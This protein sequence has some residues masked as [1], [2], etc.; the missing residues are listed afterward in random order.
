MRGW[1]LLI[2]SLLC[3]LT[4]RGQVFPD[5]V[6][7]QFY[8]NLGEERPTCI[9]RDR[10]GF[11]YLGGNSVIPDEME[12]DCANI[13]LVKVDA[14]GEIYWEQEVRLGGCEELRDMV[15]SQDGGVVFV[16]VTGSIV[17]GEEQGSEE[18]GGNY[19]AG[20]ID[21]VGQLEWIQS[22]GG[23]QLDQA[24]ALA[25]G[26]YR[27]FMLVGS[28]HSN[29]GQVDD[30]IGMS[31]LWTLKVDT[32]GQPRFSQ[33]LGSAGNDWGTS[34]ALT[35]EGDYLIAGYTQ[36]KVKSK[37][38]GQGW[39][40]RM[41]P[42][43]EILWDTVLYQPYGGYI[44]EIKETPR[45]N[46]AAVGYR[47]NEKGD[48]DFWW[49]LLDDQGKMLWQHSMD[50]PNQERLTSLDLTADGGLI[51]G[52]YAE[53]LL[54]GEG[55]YVK[56]G[57]DFWLL[58]TDSLGRLMW[59]KTYGGREDERCTGVVAYAPGVYYAIGEKVNR[60]TRGSHQANLDYWFLRVE[61]RAKADIE[62]SIFVRAN[63]FRIDRLQPTRFR[64]ITNY[65]DRFLW[66]FGDGTTS[67]EA[68][69]L[70]TYQISG[71]YEV[72]L[73]IFVNDHC[74]RTVTLERVL[75]VW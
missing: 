48:R 71:T 75:E 4:T 27:E 58:R 7:Q 43:G 23:S 70:K 29:D 67:D 69:P 6:L 60:F 51:L 63:D 21:S 57:E 10:E 74:Q 36:R 38:E 28:T 64:A 61:E 8:D 41:T 55:D 20:K 44:T 31:D 17:N 46:I 59:R 15:P 25:E 35:Q 72:T 65:G 56:G 19:F 50:G 30:H 68:E 53:P 52:G 1:L 26:P 39:V 2:F 3:S 47:L 32:R 45:G 37:E 42:S 40:L 24:Y 5:L 33:V 12:P 11:L 14:Q 73:T 62:A 54:Q 66:D 22:Y 13:W 34:V 18:Y 16:G 49:T 9:I